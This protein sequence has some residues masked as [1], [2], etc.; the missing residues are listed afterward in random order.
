MG[1]ALVAARAFE[2]GEVVFTFDHVIWRPRRDAQTVEGP[3]GHH[4]HDPLLSRVA[5]ACDPNCRPCFE[6]MALMAR[7]DIAAGERLTF[8]YLST[9]S[10][11]CA[12]FDCQC[13]ARA[14]RGRIERATAARRA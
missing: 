6:L 2:A 1:E 5:H 11:I 8:D 3:R 14:C 9:E 4:F 7:R 12:P 13:G 10:A